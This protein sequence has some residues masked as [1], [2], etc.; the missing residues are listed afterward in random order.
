MAQVPPA[1]T[2]AAAYPLQTPVD[3]DR[4]NHALLKEPDVFLSDR[5]VWL[6]VTDIPI[7][8][9]TQSPS[10]LARIRFCDTDDDMERFL[11]MKEIQPNTARIYDHLI[12]KH[13]KG[14]EGHNV[15]PS[16]RIDPRLRKHL[17]A[18][19]GR[20]VETWDK[21]NVDR[22]SPVV[23][24]YQTYVVRDQWTS[25]LHTQAPDDSATEPMMI[26]AYD[27]E[28][29]HVHKTMLQFFPVQGDSLLS[30]HPLT[31]RP[32]SSN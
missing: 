6:Q 2:L 24:P 7:P 31:L 26:S 5:T 18:V 10:A 9:P 14:P 12:H 1:G 28:Q 16:S 17:S 30:E 15:H 29:F 27:H 22:I 11:C 8:P 25:S 20:R 4:H 23:D 13:L 3:I 32:F 21:W 19:T